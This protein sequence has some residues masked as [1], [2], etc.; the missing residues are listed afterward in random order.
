M[1]SP[2]TTR[3]ATTALQ[4]RVPEISAPP[5]VRG[6]RTAKIQDRHLERLAI[7]YVRQSSL[8]QVI[9]HPESRALEQLGRFFLFEANDMVGP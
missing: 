3:I 5:P 1:S 7:V 6:P 8:H 2:A 9:E 4:K